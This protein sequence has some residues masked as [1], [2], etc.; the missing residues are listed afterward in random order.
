MVQGDHLTTISASQ[1]FVLFYKK[2]I[3]VSK[4]FPK[5]LGK[6]FEDQ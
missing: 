2:N 6:L 4:K 1:I 5:D 3:L